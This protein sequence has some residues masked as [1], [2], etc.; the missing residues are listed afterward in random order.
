[1]DNLY[2]QSFDNANECMELNKL[3]LT[4]KT[5]GIRTA[6]WYKH[7]E[8]KL[9]ALYVRSGFF[10]VRYDTVDVSINNDMTA[11]VIGNG[12]KWKFSLVKGDNLIIEF[13]YPISYDNI[14]PE[15]DFT[16][17]VEDE[18]FNWG[19]FLS[20]IINNKSRM[21]NIIAQISGVPN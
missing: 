20:N 18:D 15:Y 10:F 12:I 11:R 5:V 4:K 6:G 8:G 13:D 7:L 16:P 17:F 14:N 1:M 2:L 9:S 21:D 3:I 19:L